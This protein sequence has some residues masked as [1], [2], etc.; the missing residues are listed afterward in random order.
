MDV[1]LLPEG[2]TTC[3]HLAP[4]TNSRRK[5]TKINKNGAIA[6]VRTSG[7]SDAITQPAFTCSKLTIITLEQG[8]KYV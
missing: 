7:T 6:K 4:F 3:K 8:V 1:P 2:T 5:S